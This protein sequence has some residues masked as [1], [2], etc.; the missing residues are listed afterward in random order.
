L[1]HGVFH[2]DLCS[3]A[4]ANAYAVFDRWKADAIAV[5]RRVL[6]VGK[7]IGHYSSSSP[8]LGTAARFIYGVAGKH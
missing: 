2:P 4:A 7:G 5:G 3:A 6:A 1:H 8:R